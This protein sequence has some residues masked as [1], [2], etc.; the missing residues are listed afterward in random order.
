MQSFVF[1]PDYG[2]GSAMAGALFEFHSLGYGPTHSCFDG[3]EKPVTVGFLLNPVSMHF[4]QRGVCMLNRLID[5]RVE[6]I[7][8]ENILPNPPLS[9]GRPEIVKE[10]RALVSKDLVDVNPFVTLVLDYDGLSGED[11]VDG[12]SLVEL[13]LRKP[14]TEEEPKDIAEWWDSVSEKTAVMYFEALAGILRLDPLRSEY[15][16]ERCGDQ[17]CPNCNP[18][19]PN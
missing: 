12:L 6:P 18:P 19:A 5:E 4:L 2:N 7:P 8:V 11:E 3:E 16:K 15:C 13:Q 1:D 9:F 14:K 10:A 17:D